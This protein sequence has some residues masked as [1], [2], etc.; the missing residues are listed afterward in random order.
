LKLAK[1]K[2]KK[3]V[4]GYRDDQDVTMLHCLENPRMEFLRT[5]AVQDCHERLATHSPSSEL[6]VRSKKGPRYF[7]KKYLVTM[8]QF[9]QRF[10]LKGKREAKVK[11]N[12]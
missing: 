3:R 2:K 11:R 10:A 5:T 1:F 9:A 4:L 7:T 12:D 8:R 6:G